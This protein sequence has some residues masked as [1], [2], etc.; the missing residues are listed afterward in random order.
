MIS[1]EIIAAL[2]AI[3]GYAV[4]FVAQRLGI[5]RLEKKVDKQDE[6]KM[7]IGNLQTKQTDIQAMIDL[8]TSQLEGSDKER[9]VLQSTVDNLRQ[10]LILSTAELVKLKSEMHQ[11]IKDAVREAVEEMQD[12][13]AVLR[14]ETSKLRDAL[15]QER[16]I[17]RA[18]QREIKSWQ[19]LVGGIHAEA[20]QAKASAE[21]YERVAGLLLLL[22]GNASAEQIP[23]IAGP[24]RHW[25]RLQQG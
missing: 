11:Q 2:G 19:E 15:I 21:Q 23:A 25:P 3:L 20:S 14:D 13:V 16:K 12:E 1:P 24:V 9:Q 22:W 10:Q 5:V 18:R 4:I 7:Q 8:L 17:N 6:Q